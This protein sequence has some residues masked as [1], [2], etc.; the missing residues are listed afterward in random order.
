M[1]TTDQDAE[2]IQAVTN[3]VYRRH[4]D[5]TR[6]NIQGFDD[7]ERERLQAT[8]EGYL[9]FTVEDVKIEERE[10]E[11][12]ETTYYVSTTIY[13]LTD[14]EP[15]ISDPETYQAYKS[16]DGKNEW[17]VEWHSS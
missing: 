16:S 7:E 5:L 9:Q 12:D 11:D 6:W 3:Y 15:F 1:S 13:F 4:S 17:I 14:S 10:V 8:K 2:A